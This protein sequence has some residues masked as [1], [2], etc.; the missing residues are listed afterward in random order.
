MPSQ[1]ACSITLTS[2]KLLFMTSKSNTMKNIIQWNKKWLNKQIFQPMSTN[3]NKMKLRLFMVTNFSNTISLRMS[4]PMFASILWATWTQGVSH[5]WP[6][7]IRIFI[8]IAVLN[9]HSN[10][11]RYFASS[12]SIHMSLKCQ[13]IVFLIRF[14]TMYSWTLFILGQTI[15]ML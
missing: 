4:P 1:N 13:K 8:D 10:I 5:K 3:K 2:Q 15:E 6:V 11:S 12:S 7:L 9:R 14:V